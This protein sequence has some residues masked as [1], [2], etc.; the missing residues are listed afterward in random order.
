MQPEP[1]VTQAKPKPVAKKQPTENVVM[2]PAQSVPTD[3]P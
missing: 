2:R 1:P 3:V